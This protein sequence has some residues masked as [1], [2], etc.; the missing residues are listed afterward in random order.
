MRLSLLLLLLSINLGIAQQEY[1]ASDDFP[2]GKPNPEA[3]EEVKDFHPLIGINDCKSK[4]RKPDGSWNETLDMVWKFR[5]ILNGRGVQ[6]ETWI[7]DGKS[8]GSIRQYIADSSKWYVH[9]YSSNLPTTALP[10]WEGEKTEG[11]IILYKDQ[12]APNGMEGKY[13]ITFY[14]LNDDSFKWKG[15]W[16]D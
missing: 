5:Y 6:D 2:F 7:A 3:P 13:R 9:Y 12:K 14:D 16:V 8:A 11:Q 15:E 1:E 4:S 10:A